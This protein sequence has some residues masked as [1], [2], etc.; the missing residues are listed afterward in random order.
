[1][2]NETTI[3]VFDN[4]LNSS[5]GREILKSTDEICV[6]TTQG[7]FFYSGDDKGVVR[8]IAR[9]IIHKNS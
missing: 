9:A 6:L 8:I 5:D 2:S 7:D 1:M 3:K 4:S